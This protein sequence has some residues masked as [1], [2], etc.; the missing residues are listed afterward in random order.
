MKKVGIS[1]DLNKQDREL[2]KVLWNEI[3]ERRSNGEQGWY[4]RDG[5]LQN[6]NF[7]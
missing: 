5:K 1:K 7:Q 3:K 6:R 2:E 4:I